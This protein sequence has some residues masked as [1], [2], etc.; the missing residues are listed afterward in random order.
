MLDYPF[1]IF[2]FELVPKMEEFNQTVLNLNSHEMDQ[3]VVPNREGISI[4]FILDHYGHQLVLKLS[5]LYLLE[6]AT[7][8]ATIEQFEQLFNYYQENHEINGDGCKLDW[9]VVI[10]LNFNRIDVLE[11]LKKKD[12]LRRVSFP[13]SFTVKV[14][15]RNHSINP[16]LYPIHSDNLPM[17]RFILQFEH[18]VLDLE[19]AILMNVSNSGSLEAFRELV[20]EYHPREPEV[21]KQFFI[22]LSLI[23]L[24]NDKFHFCR[25]R[26]CFI[27]YDGNG[28]FHCLLRLC[29]FKVSSTQKRIIREFPH[30]LAHVNKKGLTPMQLAERKS[31]ERCRKKAINFITE[32]CS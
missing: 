17:L 19:P 5:N 7:V 20:T 3:Y 27:D 25:S 21:E 6:F 1:N 23:N 2:D 12:I 13:S 22:V 4:N 18:S 11:F 31:V 14:L 10:S 32:L 15:D 30:M 26:F 9:I 16:L 29:A 24:D 28:L 8:F